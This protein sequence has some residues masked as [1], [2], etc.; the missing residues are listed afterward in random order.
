MTDFTLAHSLWS[1]PLLGPA[2]LEGVGGTAP[3]GGAEESVS[4]LATSRWG[5]SLCPS[6][7]TTQCPQPCGV[8]GGWHDGVHDG[9][10]TYDTEDVSLEEIK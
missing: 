1:E 9:F 3:E 7:V 4:S 2:P 6:I 10:V 8:Y 5:P